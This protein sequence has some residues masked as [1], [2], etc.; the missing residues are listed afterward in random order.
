M[1]VLQAIPAPRQFGFCALHRRSYA[2][3]AGGVAQARRTDESN[4]RSRAVAG[5]AGAASGA[6]VAVL[7]AVGRRGRGPPEGLC[8]PP[9]RPCPTRASGGGASS[10]RSGA[11]Y[12]F[13]TFVICMATFS[14][15]ILHLIVTLGD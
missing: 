6:V 1:L 7:P 8:L 10:V 9:G 12:G 2:G 11:R 3:G 5:P 13:V 4:S 15:S 14:Y